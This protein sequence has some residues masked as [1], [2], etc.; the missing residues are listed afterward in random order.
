MKTNLEL[1]ESI[2]NYG[3]ENCEGDELGEV[4]EYIELKDRIIE[5]EKPIRMEKRDLDF[6]GALG[7]LKEGWKISRV[8]WPQKEIW[9]ELQRPDKNSKMTKPYIYMCKYGDK[10][11]CDLSCESIMAEDWVII[12]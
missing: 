6:A 3:F 8:G 1:L 9:L 12:D 5:S 7:A 2:G 10:F 4:Q 11:P